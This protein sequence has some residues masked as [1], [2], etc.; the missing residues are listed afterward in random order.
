MNHP[1][2]IADWQRTFAPNDLLTLYV[3]GANTFY[4]SKLSIVK[5]KQKWNAIQEN[6]LDNK[7]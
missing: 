3:I 7:L 2:T 6:K 5:M 1:F 4:L